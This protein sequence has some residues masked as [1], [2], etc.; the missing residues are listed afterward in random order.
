M[1]KNIDQTQLF[2][3]RHLVTAA[4]KQ[5]QT[6]ALSAKIGG[7]KGPTRA[8]VGYHAVTSKIGFSKGP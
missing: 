3:F 4:P 8:P 1:T 7:P 2:G 5:S 6:S